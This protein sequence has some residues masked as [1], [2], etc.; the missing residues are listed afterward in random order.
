MLHIA[1]HNASRN[2]K[3]TMLA[4]AL[5]ASTHES[6]SEN[7]VRYLVCIRGWFKYYFNDTSAIVDT[8]RGR[9]FA[10]FVKIFIIQNVQQNDV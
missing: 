9:S 5:V 3:P 7:Q 10:I 8:K 2:R 4:G 1:Q 6:I